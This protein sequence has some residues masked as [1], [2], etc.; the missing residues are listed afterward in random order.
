MIQNSIKHIMCDIKYDWLPMIN[1][2]RQN[3]YALLI[4]GVLLWNS[5]AGTPLVHLRDYVYGLHFQ[6][7]SNFI[8]HFIMDVVTYPRWN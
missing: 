2:F 7:I 1:G 8:P 3:I 4:M 6:G 5:V